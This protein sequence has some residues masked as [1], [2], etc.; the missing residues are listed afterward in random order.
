MFTQ[1]I[2]PLPPL[3]LEETKTSL[4]ILTKNLKILPTQHLRNTLSPTQSLNTKI[5]GS[6]P[7]FWEGSLILYRYTI[8][9]RTIP[10]QEGA[11]KICSKFTEE[12]RYWSVISVK[13]LCKFIEITLPHGCSPVSLLHIFRTTFPKNISEGPLLTVAD[14]VRPS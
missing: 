14:S 9:F 2:S 3:T 8:L 1:W 7:D 12:H 6:N 4:F 5:T 11:L 13:L 10:A